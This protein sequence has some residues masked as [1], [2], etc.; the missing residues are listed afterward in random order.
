M[1]K[2]KHEVTPAPSEPAKVVN[3]VRVFPSL[4]SFDRWFLGTGR[5]AAHKVGMRAFCNTMINRT[6][7]AWNE[8]FKA[9]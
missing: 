8:L 3:K 2:D 7:E 5:K 4:I 6:K 9:Y 1:A